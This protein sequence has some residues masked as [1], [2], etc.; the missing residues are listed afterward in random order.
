[1]KA[2]YERLRA[3]ASVARAMAEE[4]ELYKAEIARHKKA[5]A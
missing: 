3:R 1:V 4:L 5:A 2:Y